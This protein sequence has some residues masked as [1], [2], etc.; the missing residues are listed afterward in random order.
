MGLETVDEV[1]QASYDIVYN[2]AGNAKAIEAAFKALKLEGRLIELS[3]Y[4]DKKVSI[5][6]GSDFHI[7]RLK[8]ISS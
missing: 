8:M 5:D 1:S 2:T 3:W 6:L 7:K 4:G